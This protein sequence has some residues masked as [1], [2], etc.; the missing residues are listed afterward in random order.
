MTSTGDSLFAWNGG[1]VVFRETKE[2]SADVNDDKPED[3][4]ITPWVS[5][6]G[7]SWQEGQP[8][9]VAGL[10]DN[11]SMAAVIEGPAGLVAVT[12]GEYANP[13]NAFV[14]AVTGMWTS[15]DGKSWARVDITSTFGVDALG[16]VAA[17]PLGYVASHI[18]STPAGDAPAVWLSADGRKWRSIKLAKGSLA[19]AHLGT[20]YVLPSG[21]LLAGWEGVPTGDERETTPAIWFSTNGVTWRETNLPGVVAAPLKEAVV[22]RN[23]TGLYIAL[24]GTWS[25]GCEPAPDNQAWR[26]TDG[27]NWQADPRASWDDSTGIGTSANGP[28]GLMVE[29]DDGSFWLG[30]LP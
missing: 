9:D 4:S 27:S 12:D 11:A 22:E 23:A 8:M 26:S 15:S 29:S 14:R 10:Y 28:A 13:D 16:D 18:S 1:Y 5:S 21:Y 2:W 19:G 3:I 25:C 7:R 24:V 17:G 20:A 30:K 6:D